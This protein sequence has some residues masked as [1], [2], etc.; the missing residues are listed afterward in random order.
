MM[1]YASFL[2]VIALKGGTLSRHLER[3]DLS[4]VAGIGRV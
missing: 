2:G 3:R 1:I 4:G